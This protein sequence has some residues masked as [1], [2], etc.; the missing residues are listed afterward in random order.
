MRARRSLI[1]RAALAGML[2]VGAAAL[3]S[4]GSSSTKLIPLADAGPL[5]SD[6]ETVTHT[7]ESADGECKGTED[8]LAKTEADFNALPG[9]VDAGL[10][11]RLREGIEKLREDA[12]SIC[13]QTTSSA[14]SSTSKSTSKASTPARTQSA[15]TTSTS[16][17]ST[18]T[19]TT[20][21]TVPPPTSSPTTGGGDGGG[22]T[23]PEAEKPT[24]T[25]PGGGT[26]V[27]ESAPS[28]GAGS[29][30]GGSAGGVAPGAGATQ[31]AAK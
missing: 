12:L 4:C 5:R 24:S 2:G 22:T 18:E 7:A 26:G 28:E 13:S 14:T 27:G 1:V 20:S 30:P 11:D 21:T 16:T 25:G 29:S 8:A 10:R 23:V 9:S 19:T 17:T 6:F 31:E 3:V 15:P